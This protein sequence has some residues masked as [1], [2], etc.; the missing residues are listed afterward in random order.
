[1]NKYA[2]YDD[3][4]EDMDVSHV[5]LYKYL[6]VVRQAECA[7]ALKLSPQCSFRQ[8]PEALTIKGVEL[9]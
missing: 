4:K 7:P 3:G 9:R 1:M 6:I 2:N 5:R 8:R